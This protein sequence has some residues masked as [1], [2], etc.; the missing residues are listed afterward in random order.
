MDPPDPPHPPQI[1]FRFYYSLYFLVGIGKA[2]PHFAGLQNL[3]VKFLKNKMS[4][5]VIKWVGMHNAVTILENSML[6][7]YKIKYTFSLQTSNFN[8]R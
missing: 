4:E 3:G 8:P 7:S 5:K 2:A 1:Y 6:L